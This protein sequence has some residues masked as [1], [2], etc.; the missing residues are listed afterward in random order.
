MTLSRP[1]ILRY[2]AVGLTVS[3]VYMLG[4]MGW[5]AAGL[6]EIA[7]NAL[8]FVTA[9]VLQYVGHGRITFRRELADAGQAARFAI[10]IGAALLSSTLI[11]GPLAWSFG[12]PDWL[13]SGLATIVMPI[14]N[15]VL[16]S[17]WVFATGARRPAE[18]C[19]T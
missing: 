6:P 2:V 8:A 3:L 13:S 5:R 11:T 18:D 9:V 1:M 17:L 15:L 7:A 16:M 12:L 14:Q 4:Y 10:M 19:H